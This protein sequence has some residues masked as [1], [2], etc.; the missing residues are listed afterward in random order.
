MAAN[1]IENTPFKKYVARQLG[2]IAAGSRAEFDHELL[3]SVSYMMFV[4]MPILALLIYIFH[5]KRVEYYLDCLVFSIHFH[6]FAF[7][8]SIAYL[9]VTWVIGMGLLILAVP[10]LVIVYF[11][12]SLRAVCPQ[13]WWKGGLKVLA[14][15]MLHMCAICAAFMVLLLGS[16]LLF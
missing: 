1:H 11:W 12:L 13:P 15:G 9:I 10:L 5:R 7:L 16:V 14:I 6:S 8:I 3:K 4:L 2:R